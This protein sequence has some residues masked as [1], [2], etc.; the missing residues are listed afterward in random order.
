VLPG[1]LRKD[2]R[3]LSQGERFDLER[4]SSSFHGKSSAQERTRHFLDR[5]LPQARVV[6]ERSET[7]DALLSENGFD[8]IQ[9]ERIQSELRAGQIGLAKNR[10]PASVQIEDVP[11]SEVFDARQD[12]DAEYRRLGQ[13]ALASG[14]VA[15]VTLAG[16][17][18]SRWTHGAGVVKALSP[19]CWLAG[20]HRTFLEVHLAKS[21]RA[22]RLSG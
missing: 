7:L 3:L 9:H 20:K 16:G 8:P 13:A 6:E 22:G 21:R 1:L 12:L 18:G 4:F 2:Q 5:L 17:A 15:V 10:L 19:F 14:A 11:A